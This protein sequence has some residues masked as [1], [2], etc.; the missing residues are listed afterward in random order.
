MEEAD[1]PSALFFDITGCA[2]LFGGEE[3]MATLVLHDFERVGYVVRVAV[4]D[5]PGAAAPETG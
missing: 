2:P 4:A 3:Q 1:E 5:T